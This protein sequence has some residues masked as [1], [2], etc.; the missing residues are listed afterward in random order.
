MYRL[1]FITVLA[2]GLGSSFAQAQRNSDDRIDRCY[3]KHTDVFNANL[4][5]HK[6]LAEM[7]QQS[8]RGGGGRTGDELTVCEVSY[9]TF[10]GNPHGNA[11]NHHYCENNTSPWAKR[12]ELLEA[13]NRAHA[14]DVFVERMSNH[15]DARTSVLEVTCD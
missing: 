14:I 1:L 4:C 9:C 11:G 8:R 7:I 15:N 2:M 5:A 6:A 3:A 10:N 13:R 12:T